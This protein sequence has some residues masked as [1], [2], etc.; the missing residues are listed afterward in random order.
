MRLTKQQERF[1]KEL[2]SIDSQAA[3]CSS[4]H[5]RRRLHQLGPGSQLVEF[6]QHAAFLGKSLAGDSSLR[7]CQR[8][9]RIERRRSLIAPTH[10][11]I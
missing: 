5:E 7:F 8:Q 9:L 3:F 10:K 4:V 2:V 1:A 11:A 6:R